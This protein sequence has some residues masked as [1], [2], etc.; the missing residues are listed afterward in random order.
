MDV[1]INQIV[2]QHEVTINQT[3]RQINVL[4]T[5]VPKQVTAE[6]AQLGKRGFTGKSAYEIAVDNG[7]AGTES[8]WL[9]SIGKK[10]LSKTSGENINSHT[11]IALVND[12]AYKLD[13]S[14]PLHQFA[15][16]GF[17]EASSV[18]GQTC[19]IKQIGELYLSGWGLTPNQHYLAGVDGALIT[20]NSSN[21]N[22]TKIIGY[23]TTSNKLQI[24]KDSLTINK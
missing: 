24:I 8:D 21:S 15:F 17:T 19:T 2:R 6:I 4:I 9:E 18:M 13:A 14:N 11:P 23:A 5:S 7:F 10:E 20:D 22:F 16:V 3:A 1:I 12:L